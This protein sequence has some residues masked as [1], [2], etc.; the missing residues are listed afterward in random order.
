MVRT[1]AA[2]ALLCAPAAAFVTP[3]NLRAQPQSI[4]QIAAAEQPRAQASGIQGATVAGV[5]VLGLGAAA[6]R[7]RKQQ[8]ARRV[9]GVTWPVNTKFDPLNL[10][11][12]DAKMQRYTDV[13]IKHGRVAM[14]AT[15]GYIMPDMFRFPGCEGF[16]NGLSALNTLPLEGWI[17][18]L[19]FVGAHEVLVKP[20]QGGMGGFDLG[21]GTELLEGIDAEELERRQTV[22]RNNG[23]LAMVAFI[24]MAWQDGT[25]GKTP[26]A[27]FVDGGF[28][29]PDVDFLIKDIP[30]CS[31]TALCAMD[32]TSEMS[33]SVPYLNYPAPLK[34]WVGDEK[35]FDPLGVS[36]A[37][38]VYYLRESELKHGRVCMLAVIGWIAT[39]S[40]VRFPGEQFQSVSTI[41]AHDQMV[42]LGLMQ[43]MLATVFFME[44]YSYWL[45]AG[46]LDGSVKRDAGDYF[47]GKSFL[48][49]EPA[50]ER[51]M[52]LKELENGRLA[53]VAFGGICTQACLYKSTWPFM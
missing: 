52:R 19:A 34:G 47:F 15:V 22:E 46:G 3:G 6:C 43:P 16:G 18:L 10:G 37:L 39:D 42:Q 45:I 49:K 30:I 5:T 14:I 48:P 33:P 24:G 29:G 32:K 8:T 26:L 31:G 53:M 11:S 40:G 23:R 13:E 17:Q 7:V 12:T 9:V 38:P 50:A 35:A 41:D 51:T 1:I 28:W 21:L 27:M 25:F 44:V 20:R 2:A 4:N 36:D